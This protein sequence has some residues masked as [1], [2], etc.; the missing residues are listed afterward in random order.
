MILD[1]CAVC[2]IKENLHSHHF[3]P[4][5]YNGENDETNLLTLCEEHHYQLHSMRRKL[6]GPELIKEG[7][8]KLRDKN[9]KLG[10]LNRKGEGKSSGPPSF[11]ESH[12]ELVKN[13]KRLRRR[14]PVTKKVRS[15][16]KIAVEL[17]TLGF[18]NRKGNMMDAGTL[19][20]IML[21]LPSS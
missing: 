17:F 6:G 11:Q 16:Q 8:R 2:G 7:Q 18:T 13:A 9:K 20:R 19:R 4:K 10:I 21:E 5:V 1:F 12:P 15:Y 3:I 14:N